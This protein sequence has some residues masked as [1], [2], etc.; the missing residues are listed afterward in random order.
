MPA[1]RRRWFSKGYRVEDRILR[2]VDGSFSLTNAADLRA[3]LPAN[4]SEP[5]TTAD[6]ARAVAI[7]RW[8]AQ[9]MAYCLRA[10]GAVIA[11]GKSG[12][13]ILYRSREVRDEAA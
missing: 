1:V 7:P 12:N 9:K 10:A 4:L 13:A 5:F 3:L 2:S 6:I 11:S 8:L